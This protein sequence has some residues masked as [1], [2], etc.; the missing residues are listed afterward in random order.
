MTISINKSLI[1]PI[2]I[3]L[4]AVLIGG[5]LLVTGKDKTTVFEI[6]ASQTSLRKVD[7]A[8]DI[9]FGIGCRSSIFN[10]V[11]AIRGVL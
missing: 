1:T 10:S 8:I 7:L 3:I 9:L 5:F 4:L 6:D 11:Q 2:V